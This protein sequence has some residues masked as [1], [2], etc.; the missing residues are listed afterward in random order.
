VKFS[1][2]QSK[3]IKL[4]GKFW[5]RRIWIVELSGM[6]VLK[7]FKRVF[8]TAKIAFNRKL[9]PFSFIYNIRKFEAHFAIEF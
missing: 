3:I 9:P 4:S 1:C 7:I 2:Q 6:M 8:I 5:N